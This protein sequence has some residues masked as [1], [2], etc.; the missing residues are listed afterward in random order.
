MGLGDVH[1]IIGWF[2][3]TK[4][5]PALRRFSVLAKPLDSLWVELI[6]FFCQLYCRHP[7]LARSPVTRQAAAF[8]LLAYL[9]MA[10]T[11][12]GSSSN[13]SA[14]CFT[15]QS[16][17]PVQILVWLSYHVILVKNC[18]KVVE[19]LCH[20]GLRQSGNWCSDYNPWK[21]SFCICKHADNSI[22]RK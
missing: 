17:I 12:S 6:L 3:L 18:A 16:A 19:T 22:H 15:N 21:S 14:T 10:N 20:V 9:P 4:L 1:W 11:F 2:V 7:K 5:A 8:T 13:T